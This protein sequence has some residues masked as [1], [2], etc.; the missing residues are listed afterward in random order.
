MKL[1]SHSDLI[2]KSVKTLYFQF[3]LDHEDSLARANLKF[4]VYI[5]SLFLKISE[6]EQ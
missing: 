3:L 5:Q 2:I 4:Y 1:C 6:I